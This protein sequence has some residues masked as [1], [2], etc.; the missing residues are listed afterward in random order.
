MIIFAMLMIAGI[1]YALLTAPWFISRVSYRY[2][3]PYLQD[4][5]ISSLHFSAPSLRWPDTLV[6]HQADFAVEY[7]GEIYHLFC[8][9]L[10]LENLL[11][12]RAKQPQLKI[13]V[14]GL[15]YQRNVLGIFGLEGRFFLIFDGTSLTRI[16]GKFYT[17]HLKV[18][19]YLFK[20]MTARVKI[21]HRR[22]QISEIQSYAY[23]GKVGGE[24]VVERKPRP[25]YV[26]WLEFMQVDPHAMHDVNPLIFPNIEGTLQGSLRLTAQADQVDLL[27]ISFAM[28]APG[29]IN[30]NFLERL[31]PFIFE[32]DQKKKLKILASQQSYFP[33]D[34]AFFSIN[35]AQGDELMMSFK[36]EN[37][38]H[39]LRL[40]GQKR[41][42]TKRG[43]RNFLLNPT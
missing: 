14:E 36:L 18:G 5:K 13:S 38:R 4:F 15:E 9:K 7:Q 29:A 3:Q 2:L 35:N 27:D 33:L 20:E 39:G 42:P 21:Q 11:G 34:K 24:I 8:Q 37:E 40:R 16:E 17:K 26:V 6:L 12:L 23:G 32:T 1:G 31:L 22:F 19:R 41:I 30:R 10:T 43:L 28:P 25:V